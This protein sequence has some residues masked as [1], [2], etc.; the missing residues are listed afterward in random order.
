V[1][2]RE[3]ENDLV[4][5]VTTVANE[6]DAARMARALVEEKSFACATWRA[7]RSIY[8]WKGSIVDE[9]EVEITFKTL[10]SCAEEAERRLRALHPYETPAILRVPVVHTNSDY[11]DW[12]RSNVHRKGD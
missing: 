3:G 11:A 6:E 8:S 1:T 2:D 4:E 12:V 7:V 10:A 9:D 5:I